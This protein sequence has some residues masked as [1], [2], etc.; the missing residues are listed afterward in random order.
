MRV[1]RVWSTPFF[2]RLS[3]WGPLAIVTNRNSTGTVAAGV[4]SSTCPHFLP[5]CLT[6]PVAKKIWP[7]FVQWV[8]HVFLSDG[9][10]I[11]K[12]KTF[13]FN[14]LGIW[15]VRNHQYDYL[16]ES[17]SPAHTIFFRYLRRSCCKT[18]LLTLIALLFIAPCVHILYHILF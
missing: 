7:E 16:S 10:K 17:V 4:C 9:R 14:S 15:T 12:D 3:N 2:K 13:G 6:F 1:I 18:Y 11:N 8:L 5:K